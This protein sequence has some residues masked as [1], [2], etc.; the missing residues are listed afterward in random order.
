MY[1]ETQWGKYRKIKAWRMDGGSEYAPSKFKEMCADLGQRIEISTP[2]APWQDGRAERSIRTI[3]GKVRKTMIA[4]EIPAHLWPEIFSA[5]IY[6]N[7]RT[8]TSTLNGKT[9]VEV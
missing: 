5:C 6:I 3:I 4:M 8:C 7:N 1:S 9:P 2:Y